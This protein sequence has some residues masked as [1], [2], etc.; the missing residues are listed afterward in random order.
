[1]LDDNEDRRAMPAD[2]KAAAYHEYKSKRAEEVIESVTKRD[3]ANVEVEQ[4]PKD[5][6]DNKEPKTIARDTASD[7]KRIEPRSPREDAERATPHKKFEESAPKGTIRSV[8]SKGKV[9]DTTTEAKQRAEKKPEPRKFEESAPKGTLR[10]TEMLTGKTTDTTKE[11]AL[12]AEARKPV[13]PAPTAKEPLRGPE[14]VA[15]QEAK[16]AGRE[17]MAIA[18][19]ERRPTSAIELQ[20]R[21]SSKLAATDTKA[22]DKREPT[23]M[24]RA[25]SAADRAAKTHVTQPPSPGTRTGALEQAKHKPTDKQRPHEVEHKPS[26]RAHAVDTSVTKAKQPQATPGR[27]TTEQRSHTQEIS[28]KDKLGAGNVA[29]A[30]AAE[31]GFDGAPVGMSTMAPAI[32]RSGATARESK[33]PESSATKTP[34]PVERG[35]GAA[36]VPEHKAKGAPNVPT[37]AQAPQQ[38]A[39]VPTASKQRS[40]GQGAPG[41]ADSKSVLMAEKTTLTG[42]AELTMNGMPIGEMKLN[43]RR[44]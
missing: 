43:L 18:A 22:P 42:T 17:P 14:D 41:G 5:A 12:K 26:D 37:H 6:A 16:S 2:P 36:P 19:A 13:Q 38:S 31:R 29:T 9:T 20:E 24:A 1:M 7:R 4:P 33:K 30:L 10:S 34:K 11:A 28:P 8:D 32:H 39:P 25:E 3:K 15:K 44:S 27:H 35:H 21:K 23:K 40:E